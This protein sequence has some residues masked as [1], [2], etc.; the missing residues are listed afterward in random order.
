M[1]LFIL[2]NFWMFMKGPGSAPDKMIEVINRSMRSVL[3]Y[4]FSHIYD[5]NIKFGF[6]HI[7]DEY[8]KLA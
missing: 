2:S 7:Y 5:A 8:V 6:I 4:L 1:K 3:L